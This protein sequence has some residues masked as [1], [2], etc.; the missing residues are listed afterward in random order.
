MVTLD[1]SRV[2]RKAQ[3]PLELE[4]Y[5][6]HFGPTPSHTTRAQLEW[7]KRLAQLDNQLYIRRE[8]YKILWVSL[9]SVF[10]QDYTKRNEMVCM[11]VLDTPMFSP[12][13]LI[14]RPHIL[15]IK[16]NWSEDWKSSQE[17]QISGFE[18]HRTKVRFLFFV[19]EFKVTCYL[20]WMK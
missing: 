9:M 11:W 2:D 16:W 20:S 7:P 10:H 17:L 14:E 3:G 15:G 19:L 13:K 8:T 4:S 12:W 18:F 6:F 5:L 1:L